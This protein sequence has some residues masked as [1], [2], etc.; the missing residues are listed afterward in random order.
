MKSFWS[1][2]VKEYFNFSK[3]ERN[4]ILVLC[5]IL[6]VIIG[7]RIYVNNYAKPKTLDFS[8]YET[9]IDEFLSYSL[10]DLENGVRYNFDPNLISK[11]ELLFM[12]LSRKTVDGIIAYREKAYKF[13]K[14]EDLMKV[15][16]ITDEEYNAI[17]DY[18]QIEKKTYSYNKSYKNFDKQPDYELFSFDPNT[19]SYSDLLKLGFTNK[20]ANNII[21]YRNKGGDFFE[22]E[23]MLKLYT[24]DEQCFNRIKPYIQI[25]DNIQ[26]KEINFK[27]EEIKIYINSA[28]ALEFQK[29]KGIGPYYSKNIVTYREK[30]GGFISKEQI[31]EVKDFSPELYESIEAQLVLDIRPIKKININKADYKELISHPYINKEI[32]LNILNYR[33]FKG[34]IT[35]FDELIKQKALSQEVFDRISN[36]I[37]LE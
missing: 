34:E 18:V 13:W 17:K 1:K 24:I 7:L 33:E 23:D 28:D 14:T 11:E 15:Y 6:F 32:T 21:N 10:P 2:F 9:E 30:L 12:G 5:I 20:Q 4:G 22:A 19:V 36:Y 29:L 31:Q 25:G 27:N 26:G 37:C 35:S 3:R 16:G 8:K